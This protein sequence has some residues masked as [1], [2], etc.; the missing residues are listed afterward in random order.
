M[1][2]LRILLKEFGWTLDPH[3]RNVDKVYIYGTRRRKGKTES[4]Y[5]AAQSR[6]E[7]LDKNKIVTKL[8]LIKTGD[9]IEDQETRR[10]RLEAERLRLEAEMAETERIIE[11]QKAKR[12]Q[13]EATK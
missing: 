11:E 12:L 4:V 10:E 7:N 9:I 8:E 5:V 3:T 1:D 13:L 2:E 6:L